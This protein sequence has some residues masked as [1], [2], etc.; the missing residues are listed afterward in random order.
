MWASYSAGIHSVR[1]GNQNGMC[2]VLALQ[3]FD[4]RGNLRHSITTHCKRTKVQRVDHQCMQ[5]PRLLAS[6]ESCVN[7]EHFV[8]GGLVLKTELPDE[9]FVVSAMTVAFRVS[10]CREYGVSKLCT[11]VMIRSELQDPT[12][13]MALSWAFHTATGLLK[14]RFHETIHP[15]ASAVRSLVLPC[16][17][18]S[19]W[20]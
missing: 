12:L 20:I 7:G 16:V 18:C 4:R 19:A 3:S 2:S 13:R 15:S 5:Q 11:H 10:R 9:E 17:K 8:H 1:Y 6:A 14:A